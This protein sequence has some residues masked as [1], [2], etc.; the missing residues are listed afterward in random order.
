[1]IFT[2]SS[3]KDYKKYKSIIDDEIVG[4]ITSNGIKII[5]QS[6]HFIERVFETYKDPKTGRTGN[7]VQVSDIKEALLEGTIH[8]RK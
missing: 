2:F 6:K 5:G 8:I 4:I 3:F 1:M 7:G